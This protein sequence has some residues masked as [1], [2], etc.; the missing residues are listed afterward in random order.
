MEPKY[1][2]VTVSLSDTDGNGFLIMAAVVRALRL[3]GVSDDEIAAFRKQATSG[4]YDHLI[5]TCMDWVNVAPG[6]V[7]SGRRVTGGDDGGT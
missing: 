5:Q 1:P 4:N 7:F 6:V 3:A 2:Y